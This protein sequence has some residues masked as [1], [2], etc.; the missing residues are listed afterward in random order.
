MQPSHTFHLP[1]V[2]AT[3]HHSAESSSTLSV[4]FKVS[5][6]VKTISTALKYDHLC[7]ARAWM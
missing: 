4:V 5:V 7:N 2:V 3:V 1:G 6:I